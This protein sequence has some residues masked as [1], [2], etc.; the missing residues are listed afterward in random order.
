M[1]LLRFQ[2]SRM[3]SC[4][5]VIFLVIFWK[6]N[7]A[8]EHS[9]S[10]GCEVSTFLQI[11]H[12]C[13]S[14]C[15][16]FIRS[17][18]TEKEVC[19]WSAAAGK[20]KK[21]WVHLKWRVL[22]ADAHSCVQSSSIISLPFKSVW[23]TAGSSSSLT[24]MFTLLAV[25]TLVEGKEMAMFHAVPPLC[26]PKLLSFLLL[27]FFLTRRNHIAWSIHGFKEAKLVQLNLHVQ[28]GSKQPIFNF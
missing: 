5:L 7:L 3:K 24:R 22:Y 4:P 26:T 17:S 1:F 18:P 10:G 25:I 27:F 13:I 11:S 6:Y 23:H 15:Q 20:K 9:H 21:K 2:E 28:F 12:F 19:F 16:H 8:R 14:Y